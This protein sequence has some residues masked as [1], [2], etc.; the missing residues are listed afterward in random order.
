MMKNRGEDANCRIEDP[1][2]GNGVIEYGE[3]CDDDNRSN[4]DGCNS[5]CELEDDVVDSIKKLKIK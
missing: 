4:G 5:Y 2:C 3:E 1:V